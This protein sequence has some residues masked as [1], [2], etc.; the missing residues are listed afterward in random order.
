MLSLVQKIFSFVDPG[1]RRK[2]IGLFILMVLTAILDMASIG[3]VL[4]IAQIIIQPD[5]ASA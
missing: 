4:P 3:L 2:L 5:A 1:D